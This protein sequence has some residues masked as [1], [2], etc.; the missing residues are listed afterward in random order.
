VERVVRVSVKPAT[1]ESFAPFG[2][3]VGL[4][5]SQPDFH[6]SGL[7]SWRLD[8]E[9]KDST[10]LMFIWFDYVPMRFSKLERHFN[11]TQSFVPLND[12]AMVMVVAPKTDPSN[13]EDLPAPESV[14]AFLI[15]GDRGVMMWKGVWHALNRFPVKAPGGGFALLTSR[16]TQSELERQLKTGSQ[17]QLTQA[18]DYQTRFSV[19]FEVEM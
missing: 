9:C 3:L 11:V 7:R 13:W 2:Q 12:A 10:E 8:Y 5:D 1:A 18:V 14:Q 15:P 6:G 4:R 16:E 17:P 19:T